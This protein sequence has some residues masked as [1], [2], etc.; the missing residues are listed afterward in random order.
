MAMVSIKLPFF[1]WHSCKLGF[2]DWNHGI[3]EDCGTVRSTPTLRKLKK[4]ALD[5]R[6]PDAFLTAAKSL[7]GFRSSKS[8]SWGL[9]ILKKGYHT[10]TVNIGRDMLN[11][12]DLIYSMVYE[13]KILDIR[14]V[15]IE[16]GNLTYS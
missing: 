11:R 6:D 16:D 1:K 3:C 13:N 4:I 2:H 5:F 14:F 9:F 10:V 8:E 7:A 15:L 12:H